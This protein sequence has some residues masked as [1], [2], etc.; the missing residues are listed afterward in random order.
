MD[1]VDNNHL[2]TTSRFIKNSNINYKVKL[3]NFSQSN[4]KKT[5]FHAFPTAGMCFV[6]NS[7]TT[8]T[9]ATL[10]HTINSNS[11]TNFITAYRCV[12][13]LRWLMMKTLEWTRTWRT[14]WKSSSS[15]ENRW[16]AK[17]EAMW[18]KI[19]PNSFWCWWWESWLP[20]RLQWW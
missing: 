1:F 19:A 2:N 17:L 14:L 15:A 16:A 20:S 9:Q 7:R 5:K 6:L 8:T 3:C 11:K 10:Q 12:H 4:V 18:K 13:R